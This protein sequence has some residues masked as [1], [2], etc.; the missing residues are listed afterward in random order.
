MPTQREA[1][2]GSAL[3]VWVGGA[4]AEPDQ[5]ADIP[6]HDCEYILGSGLCGSGCHGPGHDLSHLAEDA[7]LE[8]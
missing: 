8:R 7:V 3:L 5:V 4:L 6:L 1:E 2:C